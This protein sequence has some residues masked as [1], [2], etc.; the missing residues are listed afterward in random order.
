MATMHHASDAPAEIDVVLSL[1]GGQKIEIIKRLWGRENG[2]FRGEFEAEVSLPPA[3]LS[4]RLLELEDA[5][6]LEVNLPHGQR[7][8]R[9]LT[10]KVDRSRVLAMLKLLETWITTNSVERAKTISS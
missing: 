7:R 6:V 9:G 10:Y 2:A 5:G 8:G 1:F 4:R 3:S